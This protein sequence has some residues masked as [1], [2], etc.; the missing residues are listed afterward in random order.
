MPYLMSAVD[1]RVYAV[2]CTAW[3]R[4]AHLLAAASL[5]YIRMLN[6]DV[7]EVFNHVEVGTPVVIR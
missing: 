5:G 6:S 4:W 7:I 2:H 3:P 1:G